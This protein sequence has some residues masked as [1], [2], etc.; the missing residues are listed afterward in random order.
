MTHAGQWER[1][2]NSGEMETRDSNLDATFGS[3]IAAADKGDR[4]AADA[5]FSALYA[6][7]HRLARNELARQGAPPS[8]SVTHSCT[9]LTC[10]WPDGTAYRSRSTAIYGLR[11]ACDARIDHRSRTQ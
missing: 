9:K 10:K 6:E 8:L 5:L 11:S 3:L 1:F 4:A 7:L 2:R